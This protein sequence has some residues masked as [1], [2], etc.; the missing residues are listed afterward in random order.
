MTNSIFVSA[1]AIWPFSE[2][3]LDD[4]RWDAQYDYYKDCLDLNS[5]TGKRKY[6]ASVGLKPEALCACV[7]QFASSYFS[8]NEIDLFEDLDGMPEW[9]RK[10]FTSYMMTTADACQDHVRYK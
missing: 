7:A 5:S 1:Y 10:K 8:D 3:S 2:K 9:R 4:R 6:M